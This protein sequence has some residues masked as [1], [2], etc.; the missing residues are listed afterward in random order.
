[1]DVCNEHSSSSLYS[2]MM[3]G[4]TKGGEKKHAKKKSNV[5]SEEKRVQMWKNQKNKK[6]IRDGINL[7]EMKSLHV[8]S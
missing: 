3:C 6:N 5:K 8:S 4:K 2:C 7:A 1:M